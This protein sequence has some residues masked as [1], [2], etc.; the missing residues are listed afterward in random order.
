MTSAKPVPGRWSGRCLCG[1]VTFTIDG[2][3]SE[4]SACHCAQCRRQSGHFAVAGEVA[5]ADITFQSNATLTWYRSSSFARRGFCQACGSALF[6]RQDGSDDWSVNVGSLDQPTGLRLAAH[7]FVAHKGD[8]YQI[9]DG[10][11]RAAEYET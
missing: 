7:I 10:L 4:L 6:W 9:T 11:P 8:Y 2:A 5:D 1:D 3:M